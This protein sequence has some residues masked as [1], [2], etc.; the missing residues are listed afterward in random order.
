[1]GLFEWFVVG[2]IAHQGVRRWWR[3][4]VSKLPPEQIQAEEEAE[5]RDTKK[6]FG[7][8]LLLG[9]AL[10]GVLLLICCF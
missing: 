3:K 1:V 9:V 5:W 6:F 8:L 7:C 4:N 10:I 2:G